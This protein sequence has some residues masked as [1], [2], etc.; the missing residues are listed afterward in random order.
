[1][2]FEQHLSQQQKQVQKLAMTQQLQQSIQILQY[3][4]EELHAYIET[5]SL[6]NPLIDIQANISHQDFSSSG[7]RTYSNEENNYLNQIPDSHTSL[8]EF[9]ID[10]I[11]LNYRDTHLRTLVLFLVE[12]IDL[13]GYLTIDLDEAAEKTGANSIEMLDALTL[14]Q[15]LDPAGVGARDLRECLMLQVER[16]DTAPPLAY[17]VI[18]EEFDQLANRKWSLIAKKFNVDL[19]DIQTIFDYIQ[20]LTPSPGS[21]FESTS[22]LYIR[23]DLTLRIKGEQLI[24]LS[25]KKG[26]PKLSFQQAYFERM[27]AV[28]DKEVQA[29]IQEKKSEFEWLEKTILQRGDT[30]LR[31][32]R[33]IVKRQ[34]AFFFNEERP[35][36]P[37]NLKEIAETLDVHESTVSRAVNG[38]Y[39][40]TEFGVF[41]LKSFFSHGLSNEST[42]EETSTSS[43]KKQLQKLVDDEDKAKP[44]SD[45]KIV[46]LLKEQEIEISRR[47]VTK[48]REALGIPASSKR[49]RYDK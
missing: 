5:K 8:F 15:Q 14:I 44:L 39:L 40:E 16:D 45:Q 32:G 6:E 29:Y 28:E 27:Q 25:N 31:V 47:T 13:N 19:S 21:I 41:E 48:Y 17:I 26:V 35:L 7:S 23:P 43:I 2:K 24:V 46:D 20:T 12:F 4:S 38:K 18:E 33:E 36:V 49:K 1:M 30:I 9:L 34:R 22:G 10:Q 3:N 42:G 11:H 37:M